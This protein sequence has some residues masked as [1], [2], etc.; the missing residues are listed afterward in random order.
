LDA[1][2]VRPGKIAYVPQSTY[3]SNST[4]A[5][6]ISLGFPEVEQSESRMWEVLRLANL[7]DFV[8]SLPRK[9]QEPVGENGHQIS[10]G[11]RQRLGIARA[12]YT[13]P[14]LIVLDEATSSLDSENESRIS[15]A[16]IGL[17]GKVTIVAIAHRLSTIERADQVVYLQNG[18]QA[19]IGSFEE[20]IK[21]NPILDWR[22]KRE[23][24]Q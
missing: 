13:N 19:D 21:R 3:I 5:G 10:G 22:T 6:N 20:V 8:E 1:I 11:Q 23:S 9:L 4:I 15:D 16:I 2:A 24:K 12:L 18:H 17:K 14:S 7:A